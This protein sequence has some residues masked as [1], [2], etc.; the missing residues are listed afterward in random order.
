MT[1]YSF[2]ILTVCLSFMILT[3]SFA[4]GLRINEFESNP[5][6]TDSGAEWIEIYSEDSIDLEGYILENGDGGVYNLSGVFSGYLTIIFP[7]PWL[8]NSNESVLL[9]Q[10]NTI[11]VQAGPFND[12]KNNEK[13][14]SFCEEWEFISGTQN[15]ANNCNGSPQAVQNAQNDS[16]EDSGLTFLN[17]D[18][19]DLATDLPDI[20]DAPDLNT[21]TQNTDNGLIKSKKI[22]LN[23]LSNK[24]EKTIVT[25]TYKT[26]VGVI[27]TFIGFCVLL[28]VLIALRKL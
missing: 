26:R 11:V 10:G 27:Y 15:A 5:V 9:K 18:D 4:S 2:V 8:D 1:G 21:S 13:T 17:N 6:G 28:V 16:E 7:G 3:L 12:A 25:K 20:L 14:W 19:A 22:T 23:A 24:S